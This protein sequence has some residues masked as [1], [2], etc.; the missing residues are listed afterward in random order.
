M[1]RRYLAHHPDEVGRVFHLPGMVTEGCP[2]HGPV[3]LPVESASEVGFRCDPSVLGW[4]RPGLP[5][6]SYLAGPLKHF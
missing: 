4:T 5:V 6:L 2:G 3:H 1:I